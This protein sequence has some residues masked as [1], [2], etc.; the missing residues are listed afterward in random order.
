[1]SNDN[2]TMHFKSIAQLHQKAGLAKPK[3]PLFSITRFEDFPAIENEDRVKIICDFYQITLKTEAACKIQY[4]Q[5]MFDFDDG[6]IS[7][8]APR[9]VSI[10]DKDFVFAKKGWQLSI[11]PDFFRTY[12]LGQK[13]HDYSFF[14]YSVNEALIVSEDEEKSLETIFRQ[15]E[16]EY[17]LPIDSFSQDLVVSNIDLLLTYCNRYYNR[18]FVLRKPK[19]DSLLARFEKLLND[20]YENEVTDKG[21]PTVT[22]IAAK[23]NLSPKY[24]GDCLKSIT[25]QNT[26]QLIHE[27]LIEKAKERLST[28]QLS[29]SEIAYD[30]GFEHPQSFSKF[31]KTKTQVTPLDFRRSFN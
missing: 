28:S 21:L 30:L 15:I 7:C 14:E 10:I 4:G 26:F 1:M 29:V 5:T 18:Q 11:H 27:K 12:P 17:L 2:L 31:F 20:Y 24:L 19:N 9:Q 6:V 23:L 16:K 3:H 13:I 22:S 8:F 25:G